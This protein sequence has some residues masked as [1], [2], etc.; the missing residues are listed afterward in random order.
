ML[1]TAAVTALL[2]SSVAHASTV[3]QAKKEVRRLWGAQAPR[4]Y[5]IIGRESGWRATAVSATGDH[6]LFQLNAY[7]WRKYFGSRWSRVYDPVENVRM[8]FVVYKRAG[9][10]GP[11]RGGRWAC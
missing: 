2:A 11:W 10:F 7:T 9:G 3:A 8:G 4:A 1:T 6:G 5:C